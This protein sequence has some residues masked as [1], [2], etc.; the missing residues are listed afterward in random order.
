MTGFD[1]P[2]VIG[3][4]KM[5]ARRLLGEG[6]QQ[7]DGPGGTAVAGSESSFANVLAE[8]FDELRALQDDVGEKY[9]GL[10]LGEG[11]GLHDI[12]AA[13]NKSEVAFNLVLEVRNKLVDAWEKLSRSVV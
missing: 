4:D 5:F 2:P 3:Y 1:L 9:K 7:G 11:V 13:A 6:G 8:R 12:M 10:V